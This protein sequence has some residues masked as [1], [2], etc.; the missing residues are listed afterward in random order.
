MRSSSSFCSTRA[1]Y[2]N[3]TNKAYNSNCNSFLVDMS[4]SMGLEP[5]ELMDNRFLLISIIVLPQGLLMW[6]GIRR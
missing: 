1:G 5:I 4:S 6:Q 2:F 3:F